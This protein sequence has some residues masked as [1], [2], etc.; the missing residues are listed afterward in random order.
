MSKNRSM[1]RL[2]R[3][4]LF[5]WIR[6]WTFADRRFTSKIEMSPIPINTSAESQNDASVIPRSIG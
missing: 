4:A 6:R 2:I 3:S 1:Y 5:A